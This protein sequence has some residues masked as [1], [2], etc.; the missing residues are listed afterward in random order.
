MGLTLRSL[1]LNGL[2]EIHCRLVTLP[3]QSCVAGPG[4]TAPLPKAPVP[5]P[6]SYGVN[7][8]VGIERDILLYRQQAGQLQLSFSSVGLV[9]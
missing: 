1:V 3:A 4:L 5:Q 9:S 8:T 2:I 7:L 6:S